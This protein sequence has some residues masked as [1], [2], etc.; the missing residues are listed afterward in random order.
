MS[1]CRVGILLGKY[2]GQYRSMSVRQTSIHYQHSH[3]YD[4]LKAVLCTE[5]VE[6]QLPQCEHSAIVPCSLAPKDHRCSNT[7]GGIL[8][9]CGRSCKSSC[10]QCLSTTLLRQVQ[11][12]NVEAVPTRA[13]SRSQHQS[14]H[15]ERTLYCQHPC[16]LQ[17]S[18][19]HEC[20][21]YCTKSCRQRCDHHQCLKP[22]GEDC[23]PCAEPCAWVCSHL[24]CPV[25]CGSVSFSTI[26]I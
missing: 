2:L 11:A 4:D 7:C 16:G 20:N 15:C 12:E 9:C 26:V 5:P 14:H 25:L 19:N 17:C 18:Q 24:T 21:T 8:S 3:Q 22:C 6:K 10:S 23:S 13:I 1:S